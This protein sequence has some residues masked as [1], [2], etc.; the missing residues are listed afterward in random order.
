MTVEEMFTS[1]GVELYE[2]KEIFDYPEIANIEWF[3]KRVWSYDSKVL[4]NKDYNT[5]ILLLE[6]VNSV[7]G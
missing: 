4:S 3:L 2:L 6:R 7:R 5:V 1:R